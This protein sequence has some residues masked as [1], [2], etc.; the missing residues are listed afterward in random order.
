VSSRSRSAALPDG[1]DDDPVDIVVTDERDAFLA[2]IGGATDRPDLTAVG[3][4]DLRR[5]QDGLP[6]VP[7]AGDVD[8]EPA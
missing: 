4:R 5:V 8:R 3:E 7:L 6:V 2:R 1:A